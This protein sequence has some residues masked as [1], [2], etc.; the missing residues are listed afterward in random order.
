MSP[1][2]FLAFCQQ[3]VPGRRGLSYSPD[4]PV[5]GDLKNSYAG[6]CKAKLTTTL[7]NPSRAPVFQSG[8]FHFSRWLYPENLGFGT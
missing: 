1:F 7:R 4:F 3:P 8:M 6:T 5:L 2:F